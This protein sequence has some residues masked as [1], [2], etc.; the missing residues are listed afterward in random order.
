M[1]F[2]TIYLYR[3]DVRLLNHK[4]KTSFLSVYLESL[5][6]FYKPLYPV[7]KFLATTLFSLLQP[8]DYKETK[9]L[10]H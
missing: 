6:K 2:Y 1:L 7:R 3:Y 4:H 10:A 9:R 5:S 8:V